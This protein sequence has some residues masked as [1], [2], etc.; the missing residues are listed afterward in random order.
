VALAAAEPPRLR[1]ARANPA[2]LRDCDAGVMLTRASIGAQTGF[3][4][5]ARQTT[6]ASDSLV[7]LEEVLFGP[8]R[9]RDDRSEKKY[10]GND[11]FCS[12]DARYAPRDCVPD[13]PRGDKTYAEQQLHRRAAMAFRSERDL[14]KILRTGKQSNRR[15][16]GEHGDQRSAV[17]F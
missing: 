14:R 2:S 4:A 15:A 3:C 6:E 16:E 5:G 8:S 7:G 13:N 10:G 17:V 12:L 1:P 9:K 11:R